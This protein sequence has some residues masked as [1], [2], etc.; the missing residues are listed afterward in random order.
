MIYNDNKPLMVFG[1]PNHEF[2]VLGL[3][4]RHKPYMIFL[5]DGGGQFRVNETRNSLSSL[6]L[7]EQAFFLNYPEK[8]LY[9]ALLEKNSDIFLEIVNHLRALF[10][11]IKPDFILCDAIEFYNPLHDT[12]LPLV[13]KTLNLMSSPSIPVYEIP[14]VYQQNSDIEKYICQRFP[15]SENVDKVLIELTPDEL[16]FKLRMR[17]ECYLSL[18]SQMGNVLSELDGEYLG[19]EVFGRTRFPT[20]MPGQEYRLRY[21]WRGELLKNQNHV[22]NVITMQEHFIPY[23]NSLGFQL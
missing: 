12:T 15:D 1:H 6:N 16:S 14:L 10:F 13:M 20:R 2:A 19:T 8:L 3:V 4:Q 17:E 22:D 21:E 5:T 11:Y 9:D 23:L 18:A 7:Q